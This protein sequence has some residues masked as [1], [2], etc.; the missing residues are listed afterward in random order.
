MLNVSGDVTTAT[1][2][3]LVPGNYYSVQVFAVNI[4]GVS[5]PSQMITF[6]TNK[7]SKRMDNDFKI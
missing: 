1:M 5:E 2:N 4:G 6:S 7:T 3:G